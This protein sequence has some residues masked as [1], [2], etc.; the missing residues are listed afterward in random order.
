MAVYDCF[1]FFNELEILDIRFQ[2]QYDFIDYFVIV[3]SPITFTGKEKPLYFYE[4]REKFAPYLDKVIHLIIEDFE[5]TSDPF[6]REHH[7]RNAIIRGLG[8]AKPDDTIIITDV[9]EILRKEAIEEACKFD[10]YVELNMPMFQFYLNLRQAESGWSAPY[11]FRFKYLQDITNFQSLSLARWSR[12]EIIPFFDDAG[13][14]LR[15]YNSGW[16]F[17]HL[18]GIERLKD[19][20]AAYS[21]A[22]DPWP[23]AMRIE[24]NLEKHILVGGTVGNWC[25]KSQFIPISY[26]YFPLCI[27]NNQMFYRD[28]GFIKD[29]YKQIEDLQEYILTIKRSYAQEC[30]ERGNNESNRLLYHLTPSDYLKLVGG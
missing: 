14:F 18:G 21:H 23:M 19:K 17:T 27:N 12:H 7:Q 9:D 8:E 20:F 4:N 30:V 13:K 5:D 10:G 29:I 11:S 28:I 6:V 25:E 26:P 16:H 1:T 2:Q 15:I 24:D 22:N 3:E